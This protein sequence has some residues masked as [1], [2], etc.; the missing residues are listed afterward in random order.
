MVNHETILKRIS[1]REGLEVQ[2]YSDPSNP[3][4]SIYIKAKITDGALTVTDSECGHAPYGSWSHR[5]IRF[6]REN[7]EK[8]F[9][10]LLEQN[11]DPYRALARMFRLHQFL[12]AGVHHVDR[13]DNQRIQ[14]G[15]SQDG[16]ITKE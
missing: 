5:I 15:S 14:E 13:K 6:D 4:E 9:A 7:T 12:P 2:L 3:Y 1:E 10:F 11:D 16:K 8:V